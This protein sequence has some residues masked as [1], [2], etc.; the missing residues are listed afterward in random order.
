VDQKATSHL[1]LWYEEF[2]GQETRS[3]HLKCMNNFFVG[4]AIFSTE[5]RFKSD[6]LFPPRFRLFDRKHFFCGKFEL[7]LRSPKKKKK[8]R[9]IK[10]IFAALFEREKKTK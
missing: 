8:I 5:V 7:F 3:N 9:V 2:I 1:T 4:P 6:S 10:Q